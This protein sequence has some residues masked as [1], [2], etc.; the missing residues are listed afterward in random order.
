MTVGV[1]RYYAGWCDKIHGKTMPTDDGSLVITRKEPIGVVGQITPW[2]GPI[3]L[4]AFKWGPALAAGCTVV[5][6]PA[7]QTPLC[8]L[9]VAALTKEAGFPPGVINV[10]PGYGPTAGA[11]VADHPDI[12]KVAFTGSVE[13]RFIIVYKTL[14]I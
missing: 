14:M 8:T 9:H 12:V 7:E 1:F 6:K 10:V 5:L 11:A 3:V 2:N 4:I 13:V